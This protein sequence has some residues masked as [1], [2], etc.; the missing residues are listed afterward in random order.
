VFEFLKRSGKREPGWLALALQPDAV[1]F[2]HGVA[3]R[4]KKLIRRCG[5]RALADEK[6]LERVAKELGFERYRCLTLLPSA[7]YQ[8]LLIEA[9][10]VPA[11]ELRSAARWRIKDML[12]Y[13]V[14]QAT[15]DVLDIPPDPTGA[16]HA[17]SMYAVAASNTVIKSCMERLARARVPL[18]VID[19][20]ETA[21]R[22]IAAL[23]EPPDRGVALLYAGRDQVLFT[24]NFH[25]ELYLARRIDV[26]LAELEKLAQGGSDDAKNR[27]LLEVQRSFD[28]LERQFPFVGV[29]KLLIA[30]TPADIGLQSYFAEN[31]DLPVEE[32]RLDELL[33]IPPEAEFGRQAAWRLFHVLGAT[34]RGEAAA[35]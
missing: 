13:P 11:A 16:S 2:A 12:D 28:H 4:E 31:L 9:P 35:P 24:V 26:A 23:L 17:H 20:A 7:D 8:V 19:I 1:H 21:Q 18:S 30:Q 29:A 22:N 34:L 5:T 33:S 15:V 14:D 27:I 10:N 25:G 3:K 32:L 6:D